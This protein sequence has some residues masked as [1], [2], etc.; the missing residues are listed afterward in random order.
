MFSKFH[1]IGN[2][3]SDLEGHITVKFKEDVDNINMVEQYQEYLNNE[4]PPYNPQMILT[5]ELDENSLGLVRSHSDQLANQ[6]AQQD[7]NDGMPL[8][9]FS[10][11]EEA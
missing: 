8:P 2:H 11:E 1:H 4:V 9:T 5:D 7:D 10:N 6:L 3:W